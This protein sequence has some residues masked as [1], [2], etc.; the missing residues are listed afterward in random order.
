MQFKLITY[1]NKILRNRAKKVTALELAKIKTLAQ[2]YLN[3]MIK[4]D[5]IGLAANQ[6]GILERFLGA[7]TDAGP[8]IFINPTILTHG[9]KKVVF[10]EG[11][12]SFPQVYGLVKRPAWII[13][14]YT[15]INGKTKIK[16]FNKLTARVIQHETDHL[17]GK[18]FIDKIFQY[19]KGE[20]LIEAWQTKAKDDEL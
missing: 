12:L 7:V 6:V 1:P 3:F 15:D 10:E 2:D 4:E 16:R 14:R 17:N 8:Q 13:L 18:L 20:K 9:L 11:C 19:T 5:G